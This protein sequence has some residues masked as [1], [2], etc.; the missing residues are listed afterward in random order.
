MYYI[1]TDRSIK[2]IDKLLF[3][4]PLLI[5][6]IYYIKVLVDLECK[7]FSTISKN[8]TIKVIGELINIPL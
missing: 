5:N 4:I 7:Y 6:K 1:I 8:L 2:G 3:F